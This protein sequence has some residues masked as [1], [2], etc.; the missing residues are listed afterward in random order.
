MAMGVESLTNWRN[1]RNRFDW[2]NNGAQF[3]RDGR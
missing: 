1:K 3:G 2:G